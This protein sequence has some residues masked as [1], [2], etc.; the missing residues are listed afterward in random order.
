MQRKY[1]LPVE[2]NS[3]KEVEGKLGSHTW[4]YIDV[5]TERIKVYGKALILMLLSLRFPFPILTFKNQYHSLYKKLVD[6]LI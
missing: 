1:D 3:T 6:F 2:S 4:R 5:G